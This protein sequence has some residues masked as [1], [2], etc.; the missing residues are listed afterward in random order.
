[1]MQWLYCRIVQHIVSFRNLPRSDLTGQHLCRAVASPPPRGFSLKPLIMLDSIEQ[2]LSNP[3]S[4]QA[5]IEAL[6]FRIERDTTERI[7]EFSKHQMTGGSTKFQ[8]CRSSSSK[9]VVSRQKSTMTTPPG[10]SSLAE[11]WALQGWRMN[12]H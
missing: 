12:T 1:M 4:T 2:A 6:R 9:A 5:S 10:Y 3:G 8:A 11:W 7:F